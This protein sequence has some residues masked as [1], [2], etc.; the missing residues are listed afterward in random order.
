MI[1]LL[2]ES[3]RTA[4]KIIIILTILLIALCLL[5][6]IVIFFIQFYN[7]FMGAF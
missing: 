1:K 6:F 3:G 7:G 5:P 4:L 2:K